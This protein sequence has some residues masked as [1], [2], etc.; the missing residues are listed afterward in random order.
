MKVWHHVKYVGVR[1]LVG[2]LIGIPVM[3]VIAACAIGF[4]EMDKALPDPPVWVGYALLA[5]AAVFGAFTFGDF[6]LGGDE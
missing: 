3:M 6:L 4:A 2:L 5:L 1:L